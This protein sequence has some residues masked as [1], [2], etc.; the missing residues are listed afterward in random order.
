MTLLIYS[1]VNCS[2]SVFEDAASVD[3]YPM[4]SIVVEGNNITLSC[5]ASGKPQPVIS[6]TRVGESGQLLSQSSSLVV[7]H[8]SR[9][10][11]PDNMIQ[12]QCTA[13][14]GVESPAI[15]VANINVHC[16]SVLRSSNFYIHVR[17]VLCC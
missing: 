3:V 5:N 8:V 10:G 4:S 7:A 9:P 12:Y 6:W 11:T 1:Q 15:A 13:S 2:F 14:N 17:H 16:K